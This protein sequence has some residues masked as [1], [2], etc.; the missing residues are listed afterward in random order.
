MRL[1][2]AQKEYIKENISHK[3][4]YQIAREMGIAQPTVYKAAAKMGLDVRKSKNS[5]KNEIIF[6]LFMEG[7]GKYTAYELSE[8]TGLCLST[9]RN[10]AWKN[11]YTVRK[12]K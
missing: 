10:I 1:T 7:D 8:L 2:Q 5:E 12:L 6:S 4:T 9:V 3:S 11:K